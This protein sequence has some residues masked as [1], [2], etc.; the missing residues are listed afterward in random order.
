MKFSKSTKILDKQVIDVRETREKTIERLMAQRGRCRESDSQGTPL[1][2]SCTED[3]EFTIYN[4]VSRKSGNRVRM[5]S[6]RGE[7][8]SENGKT[9][10]AIYTVHHRPARWGK[11]VTLFAALL[12]W[13]WYILQALFSPPEADTSV[14]T[15]YILV[16]SLVTV[17]IIIAAFSTNKKE[18]QFRTQDI[19]IMKNEIVRRIEAVEHWDD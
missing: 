6:V 14:L 1:G 5:Y 19:E 12:I 8:F 9:K 4:S 16:G 2:F 18:E 13:G 11:W 17:G 3:G 15:R 7:V 10:V